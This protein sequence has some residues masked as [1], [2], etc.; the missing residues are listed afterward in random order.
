[1]S[2]TLADGKTYLLPK[3]FKDPGLKVGEKVDVSWVKIGGKVEAT[4]VT[5]VK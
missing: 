3:G 4:A 2:I 1:M 5:V